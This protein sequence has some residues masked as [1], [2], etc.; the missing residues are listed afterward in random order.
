MPNRQ[1]E[2]GLVLYD[3]RIIVIKGVLLVIELKTGFKN[4]GILSVIRIDLTFHPSGQCRSE[5][6]QSADL[7]AG[8]VPS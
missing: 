4:R 3:F 8:R 1:F 2:N 7:K 6:R 5:G